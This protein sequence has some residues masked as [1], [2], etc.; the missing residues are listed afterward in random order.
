MILVLGVNGYLGSLLC[1]ANVDNLPHILG[2]PNLS[3]ILYSLSREQLIDYGLK[4]KEVSTVVVAAS[5][6]KLEKWSLRDFGVLSE[7]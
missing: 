7:M 5:K 1:S 4:P 2:V 3:K 6:P